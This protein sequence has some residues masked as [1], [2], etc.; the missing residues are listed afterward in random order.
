MDQPAVFNE[1]P[2]T[3]EFEA[4][5]PEAFETANENFE[6]EFGGG[7][8]GAAYG[9][10]AAR[11]AARRSSA[12]NTRPSPRSPPRP[13]P[14]PRPPG[15]PSPWPAWPPS[16]GVYVQPIVAEP[17]PS[18]GSG[19]SSTEQLRC[20]QGCLSGGS[21]PAPQAD[22]GT[23]SAD[24]QSAA[25][26]GEPAA[27]GSADAPASD[28]FEY[29]SFEGEA[30]EAE[31]P[32]GLLTLA[33]AINDP[34]ANGAGVY[35]L[36]KNGQRLYVGRSGNLRRRMQ[37][38]LWCVTHLQ[39]GTGQFHVR[40]TPMRNATPAQLSRVEAAVIDRFGR[41]AQGGQLSNVKSREL[42]QELWGE[43][44]SAHS[45]RC[46]CTKCSSAR[47]RAAPVER[48]EAT[49]ETSLPEA[50][51]GSPV[52]GEASGEFELFEL[53]APPR[54]HP[55]CA[56]L[57][58]TVPSTYADLEQAVKK[59]IAT[60]VTSRTKV[61][62]RPVHREQALVTQNPSLLTLWQKFLK[63][64]PGQK[65]RINAKYNWGPNRVES[66][67]F[68][69]PTRTIDMPGIDIVVPP[70]MPPFIRKAQDLLN[71][72]KQLG[73]DLGPYITTRLLCLLKG[74]LTPGFDDQYVSF[75]E[76]QTYSGQITRAD[77]R[78]NRILHKARDGLDLARRY[79]PADEKGILGALR[80]MDADIWKGI[81]WL[82]QQYTNLGSA[83]SPGM[84]VIK[85]R[86]ADRQKQPNNIYACYR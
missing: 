10:P 63:G 66:I 67:E 16:G 64:M 36:F 46:G 19:A 11:P 58:L 47:D 81:Q 6:Q 20:V 79:Y 85:D 50:E 83:M 51:W 57:L 73:V 14:Q 9:R 17:F 32:A 48:F 65:I 2:F 15:R 77:P 39:L 26:S 84:V 61:G 35:T 27:S 8:R 12:F 7:R 59:W 76:L 28:E 1:L 78:W 52:S 53:T 49:L 34:R 80:V 68:S 24:A 55:R 44:E 23:N 56:S 4:P 41:Q 18:P 5:T 45:P 33:D 86:I 75:S 60:C 37:Q 82:H 54:M 40:L 29:E 42:E 43:A 70:P 25:A 13:R 71:R 31:A 38:H 74:L 21:A 3:G 72:Q 69:I 22:P 62:G 30:W